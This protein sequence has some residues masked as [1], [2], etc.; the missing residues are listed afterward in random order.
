MKKRSIFLAAAVATLALASCDKIETAAPESSSKARITIGA[1]PE[2]T[3]NVSTKTVLETDDQSGASYKVKWNNS[4]EELGAIFGAITNDSRPITLSADET[5][6]NDPLFSGEGTLEDGTYNLFLFY[7]RTA[8]ERCYNNGTVGVNLKA[9]QQ[10]VL[11]SFDPSCDL[12]VWSADNATVSNGS[13][14]LE[15]IKLQR[16]MAILRINLNADEGAIAQGE[17]VTGFKMEVADDETSSERVIL[18]GRVGIASDGSLD[19]WDVTKYYSYVEASVDAAE[20]I[21][22]GESEGFNALYL[23]VNPTTIP[24]GRTIKFS[25]ETENYNGT[26]KITRTVTAPTDMQFQAG[27]VNI[28]NLKIRDKDVPNPVISFEGAESM[29]ESDSKVVIKTVSATAT[30]VEFTYTKNE[31]V[32]ELPSVEKWSY[33]GGWFVP[34][35]GIEVTEGKVTVTLTPNETQ[36]SRDN[37]LRVTGQGFTD[38]A[39]MYLKIIQEAAQPQ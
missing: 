9:T 7:P 10:P 11:Q 38:D 34:D 21:S 18:T 31:Y 16:V 27:N 36:S 23:F 12:M 25:V 20:M 39:G 2:E 3:V 28:I 8:F 15:G 30:S 22:I 33:T 13:C 19:D 29:D 26:N 6:N 32:T 5:E 4:G 14:K 37:I 1:K 35:D 24:A 17:T